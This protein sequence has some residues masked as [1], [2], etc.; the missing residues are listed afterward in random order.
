ML[1][2]LAVQDVVGALA[3]RFASEP[4]PVS[5]VS[6]RASFALNVSQKLEHRAKVFHGVL[7]PRVSLT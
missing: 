1:V 6:L 5:A 2:L 7:G 4:T 3:T